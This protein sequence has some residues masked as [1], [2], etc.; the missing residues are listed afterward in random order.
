[1]SIDNATETQLQYGKVY[2]H[3]DSNVV[4]SYDLEIL[5][6]TKQIMKQDF[7]SVIL[8]VIY[9][10]NFDSFDAHFSLLITRNTNPQQ[11]H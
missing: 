11:C 6:Y 8:E 4:M 10:N 3:M 7:Q 5:K 1:M 2:V 9:D